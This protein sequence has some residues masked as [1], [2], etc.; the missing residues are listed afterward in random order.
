MATSP[1]DTVPRPPLVLSVGVV[2][3]RSNRLPEGARTTVAIRIGEVLTL[4][5]AEVEKARRRYAS[6]F[7]G[8]PILRLVSGMA[9][10]ADQMAAESAFERGYTVAAVLPFDAETY[11]TD[12]ADAEAQQS[13][14]ALL[15]RAGMIL[16]L[17]GQRSQAVRAYQDAGE[18]ILD[19][20]DILLAVW[21]GGPSAG[22]GGT[23]DMVE[24][25]VSRGIPVVHIDATG[26]A[27]AQVRWGGFSALPYGAGVSDVPAVPMDQGIETVVDRLVRPPEQPG[28][29]ARL[30][31][32]LW[33]RKAHNWRFEM[34]LLLALTGTRRL[35]RSDFS[36]PVQRT[37]LTISSASS[38][39][40]LPQR[41]AERSSAL[42]SHTAGLIHLPGV[43]RS[44]SAVPT[45]AALSGSSGVAIAAASIVGT[46]VAG[47]PKW[48]RARRGR[49][50]RIDHSEHARR[51][52][53]RLAWAMAGDTR[54]G[55]AAA[56][57]RSSLACGPEV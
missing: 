40:C 44:C 26:A 15:A 3:H 35:R 9:E 8:D 43:M 47:W 54:G 48:S 39:L 29:A 41:I 33:C 53:R 20:A 45:S 31:G 13:F 12:F 16:A 21:D 55:G 19:H 50:H 42:P 18:T 25:A 57:G 7:V 10:G 27:L 24:A 22:S 46:Q 4:V 38:S 28:E 51:S 5:A 11:E 56:G 36:P 23:T 52:P 1:A 2:G 34:P 30:S 37:L 17:P 49:L 6:V 14:R 32:F